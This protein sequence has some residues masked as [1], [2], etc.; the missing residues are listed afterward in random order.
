MEVI[1]G[2]MILEK[3]GAALYLHVKQAEDAK[4]AKEAVEY[5][6]SKGVLKCTK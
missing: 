1:S 3:L 6:Q 2:K 5:L 4:K